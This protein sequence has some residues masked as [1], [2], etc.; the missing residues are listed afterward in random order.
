MVGIAFPLL[1]GA[2]VLVP[3][4]ARCRPAATR[5]WFR[6]FAVV[7]GPPAV[8]ALLAGWTLTEVGRQP[9]IAYRVMRVDEAVTDVGWIWR[10]LAMIVAV[11]ASMTVFG[12]IVRAMSRRWRDGGDLRYAYGPED[13][14][15]DDSV[16]SRRHAGPGGQH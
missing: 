13:E 4:T 2:V 16:M 7:A 3:A 12:S 8:A 10:S 6:R 5:P 9:W 14:E 15:D 1:G 11:Y